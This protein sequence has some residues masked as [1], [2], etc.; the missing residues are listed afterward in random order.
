MI[1]EHEL[2]NDFQ[3]LHFLFGG[4][5][6][7]LN[8]ILLLL[9]IFLTPKAI[10]LYST[11]IIN[12]AITD[13]IACLLDIFIEIRVLPYPNEDSMAHIMNGFCKYFGLTTCAVG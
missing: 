5:G 2:T 13:G 12:F 11:L 9:A 10:R 4:A 3:I 6:S 7:I 1:S 8:L